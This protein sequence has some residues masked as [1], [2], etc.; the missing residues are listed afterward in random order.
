M[1]SMD[2]NSVHSM[3]VNGRLKNFPFFTL[4]AQR[5][6]LK[7]KAFLKT[8]VIQIM[9]VASHFRQLLVTHKLH[10]YI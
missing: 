10:G 1:S 6:T 7:D 5:T 2:Q 3:L 4:Q 8:S 9:A